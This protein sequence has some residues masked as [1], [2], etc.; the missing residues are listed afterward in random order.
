MAER[1]RHTLQMQEIAGPYLTRIA[2]R[3]EQLMVPH[4]VA[5]YD[6][7][8]DRPRQ[9][10]TGLVF[11]SKDRP[12]LLTAKHSLFGAGSNKNPMMKSIFVGG[13][14]RFIAELG[15]HRPVVDPSNDLVASYVDEFPR[16]SACR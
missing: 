9:V 16:K 10:A 8:K 1:Q 12:V 3:A 7:P 4:L 11:A 2:S 6:G 5:I 15:S 13:E 14:L